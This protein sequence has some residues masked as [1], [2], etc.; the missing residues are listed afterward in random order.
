MDNIIGT[1]AGS[2]YLRFFDDSDRTTDVV[3]V[4]LKYYIP[5]SNEYLVPWN[6]VNGDR[7]PYNYLRSG[8]Y[9]P[10]PEPELPASAPQPKLFLDTLKSSPNFPLELI[11]YLG[12]WTFADILNDAARKG[13]WAKVKA[14]KPYFMTDTIISDIEALAIQCNLPLTD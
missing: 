14:S 4:D 9:D 7:D 5:A 1:P 12:A 11:P 2:T 6:I 10:I 8:E 3:F 13:F